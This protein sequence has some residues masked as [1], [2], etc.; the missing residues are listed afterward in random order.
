MQ[1]DIYLWFTSCKGNCIF[2]KKGEWI[3]NF[4]RPDYMKDPNGYRL[5]HF[6]NENEIETFL[7]KEFPPWIS[8][9][10]ISWNDPT[11][12][13]WLTR[14]VER[15]RDNFPWIVLTLRP[16]NTYIISSEYTS[17]FDRFEFSIY[18]QNKQLHNLMVWSD[19]AWDI[20]QANITEF[21]AND[22]IDKIFFQTIF[23]Y[24][25]L[26]FISEI[27]QYMRNISHN[28]NPIKIV[29][30]YFMPLLNRNS[31]PTKSTI[32]KALIKKMWTE[33]LRK[34]CILINFSVPKKLAYL[35]L[36][37]SD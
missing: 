13:N 19:Q 26:S 8:T 30:P 3:V 5:F 16:S 32:L 18:G 28:N 12:W 37:T 36:H 1:L 22:K 6:S 31:L 4:S 33:F 9:I 25:N 10:N 21:R 23:L 14:F 24:E 20:L 27:L 11:S 17:I 29:Y 15:I 34:N 35:F 2:C 7:S